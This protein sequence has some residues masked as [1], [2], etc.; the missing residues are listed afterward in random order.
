MTILTTE[1][2]IDIEKP[3][4]PKQGFPV[5][6]NPLRKDENSSFVD[7][8]FSPDISHM[9]VSSPKNVSELKFR[10]NA[11]K[12]SVRFFGEFS[13]EAGWFEPDFPEL[14]MSK[15]YRI[16]ELNKT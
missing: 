10:P 16:Y 8:D 4:V 1:K 2:I 15:G 3:P 14:K 13:V 6:T 7:S 5:C 11:I 9:P 12:E